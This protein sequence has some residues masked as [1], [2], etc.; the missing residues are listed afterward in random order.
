MFSKL[1]LPGSFVPGPPIIATR[2][3]CPSGGGAGLT[4]AASNVGRASVDWECP[5]PHAKAISD[6]TSVVRFI[7]LVSWGK[8]KHAL[9]I[10]CQRFHL[11]REYQIGRTR[12]RFRLVL[13]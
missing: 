13:R 9:Q 5:T 6:V 12:L 3:P 10:R 7:L 11:V 8:L 2:R 1:I 4:E